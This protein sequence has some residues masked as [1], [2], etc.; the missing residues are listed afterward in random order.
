MAPPSTISQLQKPVPLSPLSP[1][2]SFQAPLPRRGLDKE[3]PGNPSSSC[4]HIPLC[5][6]GLLLEGWGNF[7]Q[8]PFGLAGASPFLSAPIF[9]QFITK[10]FQYFLHHSTIFL[11][12][13]M[14]TTQVKLLLIF[15][16][17]DQIAFQL[18]GSFWS[19]ILLVIPHPFV[20][21]NTL[22]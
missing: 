3:G 18:C 11:F 14:S 8:V 9:S 13:S 22:L 20:R 5:R 1:N 16:L 10:S 19:H 21:S 15:H 4:G 2:L 6:A 12:P 17:D 7:S